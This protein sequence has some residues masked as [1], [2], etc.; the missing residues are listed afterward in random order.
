VSLTCLV[1]WLV[2]WD[3]ILSSTLDPATD[4][5]GTVVL[6][7]GTEFCAVEW[8]SSPTPH[9]HTHSTCICTCT[10]IHK[11]VARGRPQQ[12]M[13]LWLASRL[14]PSLTSSP[15]I[16]RHHHQSCRKHIEGKVSL[17]T[18]FERWTV[19]KSPHVSK[20]HRGQYERRMHRR[21]LQ[22]RDVSGVTGEAFMDYVLRMIPPGVQARVRCSTPSNSQPSLATDHRAVSVCCASKGSV[23][24][25]GQE[26]S[27][28]PQKE[29]THSLFLSAIVTHDV[30][31]VEARPHVRSKRQQSHSRISDT[32]RV[33]IFPPV[34][35]VRL[36]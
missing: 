6:V 13:I 23:H 11:P 28:P 26:F 22:V 1:R 3:W 10:R 14:V 17:P 24:V 35:R 25:F 9:T 18:K 5:S 21:L 34:V 36:H 27:A 31:G 12:R 4:M 32:S 20:Q 15:S 16:S 30:A 8:N 33:S 7:F 29:H 19:L 2:S